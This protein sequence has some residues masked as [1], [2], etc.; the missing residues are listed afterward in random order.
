MR[1]IVMKDAHVVIK[2]VE[3]IVEVNHSFCVGSVDNRSHSLW[4]VD[5]VHAT[6]GMPTSN[7]T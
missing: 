6:H 1:S 3:S 5:F 2:G 4:K 7:Q